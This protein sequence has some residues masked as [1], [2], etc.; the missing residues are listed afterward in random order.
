MVARGEES[1]TAPT[2]VFS[3]SREEL[4]L[5]EVIQSISR[6]ARIPDCVSAVR[7]RFIADSVQ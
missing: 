7:V 5:P 4:N 2:A 1:Q 6:S 3:F